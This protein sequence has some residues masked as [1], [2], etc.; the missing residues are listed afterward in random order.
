MKETIFHSYD[1][2]FLIN[3]EFLIKQLELSINIKC[4]VLQYANI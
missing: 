1:Q 3:L 4:P 2:E